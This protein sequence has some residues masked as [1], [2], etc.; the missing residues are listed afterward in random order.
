MMIGMGMVKMILRVAALLW[1]ILLTAVLGNVIACN[2]K[3]ASSATVAINFAMFVVVLGWLAS[4]IGILS[5]FTSAL[6]QPVVQVP[7]DG[8]TA[9]FSFIAAVMLAAKLQ[10]VNCASIN[11]KSMPGDWIAWGSDDDSKRC[12]EIQAGTVFMWFLFICISGSTFFTVKDARR[13]F[14]GSLPSSRPSMSQLGV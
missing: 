9:L 11:A 10:V 4:I 1:S 3:A 14:H 13:E 7:F 6:A 2:V 12:R 8:L 5:F